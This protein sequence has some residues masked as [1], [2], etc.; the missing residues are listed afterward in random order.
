MFD[1]EVIHAQIPSNI[2]PIYQQLRNVRKFN[3]YQLKNLW[4][5]LRK[6]NYPLSSLDPPTKPELAER[7]WPILEAKINTARQMGTA[8]SI[9]VFRIAEQAWKLA[10]STRRGQVAL[11]VSEAGL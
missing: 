3:N 10:A 6:T 9:P 5:K 11:F 7:L 1:V 2:Q 4:D 8:Q